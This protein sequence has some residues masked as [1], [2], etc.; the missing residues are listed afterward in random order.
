MHYRFLL[1]LLTSILCGSSHASEWTRPK[2]PVKTVFFQGVLCSQIQASKYCGPK[3]FTATTGEHVICPNALDLIYDPYIGSELE[4]IILNPKQSYEWYSPIPSIN[5]F[6]NYIFSNQRKRYQYQISNSGIIETLGTHAVDFSKL[7]IGQKRDVTECEKRINLCKQQHPNSDL[8][9]WGV[10]RGAATMFSSIALNHYKNVKLIVLEGCFDSVL[11]TAYMR[12]G[13][14]CADLGITKGS[15][16][17]LSLLTEF[18]LGGICPLNT[19]D[20]FPE[21]VPVVFITSKND[22]NVNKVCTDV[23]VRKLRKRGKNTVHYIV[24]K[25]AGHNSYSLGTGPDQQKYFT[26]LHT[27][28]KQYGL[29]YIAQ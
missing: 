9:L 12:L 4:E 27:I 28:Y 21:N 22:T 25:D 3:G 2:K 1:L 26:E 13:E 5:T 17:L 11:H 8:I 19:I 18:K 16:Y 15:L 23:L 24:L 6:Q 29:P 14:V 20:Q 7:N 10:S